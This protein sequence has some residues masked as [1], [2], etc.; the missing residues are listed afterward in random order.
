VKGR[1][2]LH[3]FTDNRMCSVSGNTSNVELGE[4]GFEMPIIRQQICRYNLKMFNSL[5][6]GHASLCRGKREDCATGSHLIQLYY[7]QPPF[8]RISY[9]LLITYRPVPNTV[10]RHV[11]GLITLHLRTPLPLTQLSV[12]QLQVPPS[13]HPSSPSPSDAPPS[14]AAQ[15][16][17]VALVRQH[18]PHV[19]RESYG[20]RSCRGL[21]CCLQR[22][23]WLRA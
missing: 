18:L 10:T 14:A 11:P 17:H 7:H 8:S 13:Q 22:D 15:S 1:F 2:I 20:S 16:W 5:E 23:H 9:N 4:R 19:Y 21:Y 6:K 12:Y 3:R